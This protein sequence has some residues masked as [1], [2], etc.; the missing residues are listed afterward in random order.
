MS[1]RSYTS[2]GLE[3]HSIG[4]RTRIG[5]GRRPSGPPPGWTRGRSDEES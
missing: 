2:L 1:V 4:V 3:S 5:T